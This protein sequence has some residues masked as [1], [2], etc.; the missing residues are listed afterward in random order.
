MAK[1][2]QTRPKS[3]ILHEGGISIGIILDSN[4]MNEPFQVNFSG[5]KVCASMISMA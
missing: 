5:E 3:L 4:G 2:N 1:R